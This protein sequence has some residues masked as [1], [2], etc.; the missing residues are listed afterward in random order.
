MGLKER[1]IQE[2]MKQKMQ[3]EWLKQIQDAAK[4]AVPVEV[5]WAVQPWLQR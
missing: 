5:K 3:S 2:E 4:I 1:R